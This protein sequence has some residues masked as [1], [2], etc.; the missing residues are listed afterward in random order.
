MNTT[1]QSA[2][3]SKEKYETKRRQ[4][5]MG[6]EN[7]DIRWIRRKYITIYQRTKWQKKNKVRMRR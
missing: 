4:V 2:L 3:Y 5:Q 7:G 6:K 1:G